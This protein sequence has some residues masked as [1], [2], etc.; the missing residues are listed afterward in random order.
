MRVC[1]VTEPAS[2]L[3]LALEFGFF[4]TADAFVSIGLPVDDFGGTGLCQRAASE[5]A[6]NAG[7]VWIAQS[8]ACGRPTKRKYPTRLFQQGLSQEGH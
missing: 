4:S 6:L 3:V 8:T 7:S 1:A 5:A 2:C